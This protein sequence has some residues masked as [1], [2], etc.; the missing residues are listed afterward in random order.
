[1][2]EIPSLEEL[3]EKKDSGLDW[4]RIQGWIQVGIL[5]LSG[6]YFVDL[7]LPG[8]ELSN[9]INVE[10]LA[11]LTWVAAG[12]FFLL[13]LISGIELMSGRGNLDE[14]YADDLGHTHASPGSPRSWLFLAIVAI[15]L[16]LGLGVPSEP[17]GA[18]AIT[19][20]VDSNLSAFSFVGNSPTINIPSEDRNLLDWIRAFNS[21]I[22]VSEFNGQEAE[23]I[24][25]VYRDATLR[26]T[27]N[28]MV[29]R[30]V[31]SCCV[32]DARP[33]G[34][35][36]ENPDSDMELSQD[37]WV[38]VTGKFEIRTIDGVDTPVLVGE[39]IEITSQP[40]QPYLYF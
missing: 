38:R 8:G 31:L 22:D 35:M 18:D 21:S 28:F 10:N 34:L 25:F 4:Q 19:G 14:H 36:V 39:T 9:Y 26:G 30:F 11:W 37:T 33:L 7:A 12:I 13:A 16:F 32:A 15:P 3:F 2:A 6:L 20:D 40:D 23:V 5:F 27:D 29:V 24:G 17:L 1:M